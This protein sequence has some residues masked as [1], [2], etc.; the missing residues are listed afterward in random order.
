MPVLRGLSFH[1]DAG[2]S[3]A[4]VGLRGCGKTTLLS[5]LSG[6]LAPTSGMVVSGEASLD[7][8]AEWQKRIGVCPTR[9]S[10]LGRL[11]V[12]QTLQLYA[13]IRGIQ[14]ADVDTLLEHV[15]LLLN[16]THCIDEKVEA[17]GAVTRRKLA[18]AIAIIGLPPLVLLDD[19]TTGLDL[20]SKRKIYRTITLLRQLVKA[21]VLVVTHSVSDGVVMSDRLAVMR[22]GQFQCIGSIHE[23]QERLCSGLVLLVELKLAT[24]GDVEVLMVVHVLVVRAFN[25]ATYS[26]RLG[27]KL[28]YSVKPSAPWSQLVLMVRELREEM[29]AYADDVILTE[30]TLE[31]A[32]LKMIKFHRPALA[33]TPADE[34]VAL[35]G[36]LA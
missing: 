4:I 25:T 14:A 26:G 35:G 27:H 5:L 15:V 31:H 10:V 30:V 8:V 24:A 28:E 7:A 3:L 1:V 20:Q 32:L 6:T 21:A 17:C 19:P 12:R 18:V 34:V 13:S 9:D 33:N 36:A 22:D 16:L 2:E 23:L 29:A 11:T